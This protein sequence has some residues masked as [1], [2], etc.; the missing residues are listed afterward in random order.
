MS[1]SD[2]LAPTLFDAPPQEAGTF[3][4]AASAG[5]IE[6]SQYALDLL[7]AQPFRGYE[8]GECLASGEAGAS[9]KARDAQ[10]DRA[11]VVRAMKPWPGRD[12]VVEEFFSLAGSVARLKSPGAVRAL[13]VGRGDGSF[14]MVYEWKS[15]ESLA[16]R[17]ARRQTKRLTE[18]ESLRLAAE[19][20]IALQSLFE[21][22]HPH[23][24]VNPSGILTYEGGKVRLADIGFAWTLAWPDDDSAFAARPDCLPPERIRGDLNI[25]V[26]GDLYS[27]GAVWH[28]ALMGEP[29][30]KGSTGAETLAMHLEKA[31]TPPRDLDPRL[32]AA[33]SG[34]ILWLLEKDRDDRPRTPKEFLRKLESH[35]LLERE[36]AKAEQTE[37][38]E[39]DDLPNE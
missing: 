33:T 23:G 12:G 27:L 37:I 20:A 7:A 21:L 13:D 38:A 25:D 15:A 19:T 17:L 8:L 1:E 11:V 3:V 29:A 24:D 22:G 9:F 31:P 4:P 28:M 6:A 5:T 39:A 35:P 16:D 26:R 14:F 18:R 32:S 36:T 10:L 34:L 2:P 30:F